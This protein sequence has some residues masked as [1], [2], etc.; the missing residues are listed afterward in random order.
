MK[1]FFSA[2]ALLCALSFL[3]TADVAAKT[4][5]S[6]KIQIVVDPNNEAWNPIYSFSSMNTAD[7][8]LD[9][10]L[11]ATRDLG[12]NTLLTGLIFPKGTVSKNQSDY[13]VDKDGNALDVDDRL[14]SWVAVENVVTSYDLTSPYQTP[15]TILSFA[16]WSY[17]FNSSTEKNNLYSTGRVKAATYADNY[18]STSNPFLYGRFEVTAGSGDFAAEDDSRPRVV[19][20]KLYLST[21]GNMLITVKFDEEIEVHY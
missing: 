15:G 2:Y 18:P 10:N 11:D 20:T 16:L 21:V 13:S 8:A 1:K 17:F 7:G 19:E 14:G 6:H 9:Y 3:A 5:K 12:V 4:Y